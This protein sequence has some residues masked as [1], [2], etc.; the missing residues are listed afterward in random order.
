MKVEKFVE[1][2]LFKYDGTKIGYV[3]MNQGAL[4]EALK[5]FTE[6]KCRELLEIVAEKAKTKENR[7]MI[8]GYDYTERYVDKDS[9]LNAVDLN[10]FIQ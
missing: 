6:L 10:T 8:N 3:G 9:I 4:E 2:H 7:S 1:T 5:S